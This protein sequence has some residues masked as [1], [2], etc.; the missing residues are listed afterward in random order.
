MEKLMKQTMQVLK[1]MIVRMNSTL[2]SDPGIGWSVMAE[3]ILYV[4]TS[5]FA[6]NL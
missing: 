2:V 5:H 3:P 1:L 4:L 6:I